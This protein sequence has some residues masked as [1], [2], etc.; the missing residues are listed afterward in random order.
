[1]FLPRGREWKFIAPLN[2]ET[3]P[4]LTKTRASGTESPSWRASFVNFEVG[5]LFFAMDSFFKNNIVVQV[6]HILVGPKVV[7]EMVT[8]TK[9]GILAQRNVYR[10]LSDEGNRQTGSQIIS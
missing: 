5:S 7:F 10:F 2:L 8:Q 6:N 4:P 1:M 9:S 3:T